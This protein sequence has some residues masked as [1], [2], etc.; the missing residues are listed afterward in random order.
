MLSVPVRGQFEQVLNGKY[1][2]KLGYGRFADSLEDPKTVFGFI[3]ALD[4][5]QKH[6]ASYVQDGNTE[7][8]GAVDEHLDR[9]AAGL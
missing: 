9:A 5:C 2:E 4:D 3:E 8:L 6:L 7:I 1:L